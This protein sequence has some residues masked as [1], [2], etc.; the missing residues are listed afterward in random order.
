[1]EIFFN[2]PNENRLP[3]EDVRIRKLTAV[4]KA[5]GRHVFVVLE[6]LPFQERPNAEISITDQDGKEIA[7]ANII[8]SM[9]NKV[10]M[11][12]HLRAKPTVGKYTVTAK[13]FF[14][15][16]EKVPGTENQLEPLEPMLVDEKKTFFELTDDILK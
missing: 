12:I 6:I 3:P 14:L 5:Q 8:E 11:N 16:F 2:T 9:F 13:L 15:K 7:S 1:M 4:P 10:E